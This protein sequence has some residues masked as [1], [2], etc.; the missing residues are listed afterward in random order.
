VQHFRVSGEPIFDQAC[1]F[2][3]YRGIG[4]ECKPMTSEASSH[5]EPD[6]N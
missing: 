3:G 6:V 1:R 4:I 2:M 5:A